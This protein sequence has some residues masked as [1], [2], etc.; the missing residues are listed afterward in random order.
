MAVL[1]LLA[2][3]TGVGDNP[4]E[5]VPGWARVEE[6]VFSRETDGRARMALREKSIDCLAGVEVP[7]LPETDGWR[8]T[9]P[10]AAARSAEA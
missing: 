9:L 8:E 1:M 6:L 7:D 5:G 3:V 4:S 10:A 2:G